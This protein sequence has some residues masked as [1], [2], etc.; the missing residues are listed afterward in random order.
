MAEVKK[1][2][3]TEVIFIGKAWNNTTK[4]GKNYTRI[5][6]DRNL[7]LTLHG[8]DSVELWPNNKREGKKDADF[9]VS[10]RQPKN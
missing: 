6:I 4:G 10:I 9:R 3:E 5:I 7:D 8:S 2:N 1:S